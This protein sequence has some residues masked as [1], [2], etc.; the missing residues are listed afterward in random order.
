VLDLGFTRDPRCGNGRRTR[1]PVRSRPVVEG[2]ED[3][4]LMSLNV[5]PV[6]S[7]METAGITKGPD[8]SLFFTEAAADTIGRITPA[9]AVTEFALPKAGALPTAIAT[10]PDGNLYF[11][12]AG[13]T[14]DHGFTALHVGR[15]SPAGKVSEF[16]LGFS[17]FAEGGI[18]AGP[19]GNLY[20][21]FGDN[22]GEEVGRITPAGAI[23]VI[24][25]PGGIDPGA[26]TTGPDGNLWVT[27]P[28]D[29]RIIRLTTAGVGTSFALPAGILS[30]RGGITGGPDGNIWFTGRSFIGRITQK[31]AVTEFALPTKDSNTGAITAGPDGNLYFAGSSSGAG[32]GRI[33]TSGV[34]TAIA[35]PASGGIA[36]GPD[37]NIWLTEDG[38]IAQLVLTKPATASP[39]VA[40]APASVSNLTT[41][42][43]A[44]TQGTSRI[45][46]E[47]MTQV[48]APSAS[49]PPA[50]SASQGAVVDVAVDS[51]ATSTLRHKKG[52]A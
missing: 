32:I 36:S 2:L 39:A 34:I 1:R 43:A 49:T 12:E 25:V 38:E 11:T 6:P 31:G 13:F 44:S 45:A 8:G 40:V 47:T 30:S 35:V 41:A 24:L 17:A 22:N 33:T 19:D 4:Q 14:S 10:G 28:D 27:D 23:R 3:R 7:G 20:F 5:F 52:R 16:S 48:A 29:S 51:L 46:D 18:T 9:G 42:A 15:I 50:P 26:I 37:G 21:S